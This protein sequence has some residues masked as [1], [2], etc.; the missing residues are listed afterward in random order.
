MLKK[1]NNKKKTKKQKND[2]WNNSCFLNLSSESSVA[3]TATV[4]AKITQ[5]MKMVET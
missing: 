4:N 3:S 2:N 5:N 1:R